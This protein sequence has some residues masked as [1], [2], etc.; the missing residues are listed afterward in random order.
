MGESFYSGITLGIYARG[1]FIH[2]HPS[3]IR[4]ESLEAS[5]ECDRR[6]TGCGAG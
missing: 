1:A 6:P 3:L 5:D 2:Y 4:N